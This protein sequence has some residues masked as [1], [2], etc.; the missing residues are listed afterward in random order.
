MRSAGFY[1]A[2]I[3]ASN[4]DNIREFFLDKLQHIQPNV[5]EVMKNVQ[6]PEEVP[7]IQTAN[8]VIENQEIAG[9]IN[10]ITSLT[11]TVQAL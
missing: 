3:T 8:T 4:L 2:N 6:P 9:L 10:L 5:I 11:A 1:Q 7:Q